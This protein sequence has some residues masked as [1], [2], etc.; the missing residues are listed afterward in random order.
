MI[1]AGDVQQGIH[2]LLDTI[3]SAGT[4]QDY[5]LI[6]SMPAEKIGGLCSLVCDW[7]RRNGVSVGECGTPGRR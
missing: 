5:Y 4:K 6:N 7:L 3:E 1:P 2:A